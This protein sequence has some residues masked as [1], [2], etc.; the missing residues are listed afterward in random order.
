MSC[1]SKCYKEDNSIDNWF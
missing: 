1:S